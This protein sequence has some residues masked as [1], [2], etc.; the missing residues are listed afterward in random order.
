[1]LRLRRNCPSHFGVVKIAALV[2]LLAEVGGMSGNF[3]FLT[4][5]RTKTCLF[6]WGGVFS[7]SVD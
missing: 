3:L 4:L 6:C 5:Q 1:L 2:R 7:S